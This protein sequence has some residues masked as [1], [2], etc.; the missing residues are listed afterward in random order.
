MVEVKLA[1][2]WGI[3][4]SRVIYV[5]VFCFFPHVMH[6]FPVMA[7]FFKKLTAKLR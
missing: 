3:S 2:K 4:H 7:A 1:I 5:N 6:D